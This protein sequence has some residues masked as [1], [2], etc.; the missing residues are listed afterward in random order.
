MRTDGANTH[1]T[2]GAEHSEEDKPDAHV[3][4]THFESSALCLHDQLRPKSDSSGSL[5]H[6]YT[7]RRTEIR[8]SARKEAA[9]PVPAR[10]SC[11]RTTYCTLTGT[12]SV[13]HPISLVWFHYTR[14]TGSDLVTRS[15]R[16]G[17]RFCDE[18]CRTDWRGRHGG[19]LSEA[20]GS[21]PREQR[22][23]ERIGTHVT[24]AESL[25]VRTFHGNE[26]FHRMQQVTEWLVLAAVGLS[27]PTALPAA[28]WLTAQGLLPIGYDSRW[29][30][31]RQEPTARSP[32]HSL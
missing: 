22:C 8:A 5:I 24:W 32:A 25:S 15:R 9:S 14:N 19:T 7:A 12:D 4:V 31:I 20:N 26:V 10:S 11:P 13:V 30:I 16:K 18:D 2:L 29:V 27:V 28:S 6:T 21:L 23:L 1:W 17:Q 3:S